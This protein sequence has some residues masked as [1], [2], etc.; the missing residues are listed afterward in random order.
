MC[1]VDRNSGKVTMVKGVILKTIF[2]T[3]VAAV[4]ILRAEARLFNGY[5]IGLNGVVL[6]DDNSP[7]SVNADG[8][9]FKLKS[10]N[11]TRGYFGLQGELEMSRPNDLYGALRVSADF[12]I[13]SHPNQEVV[14]SNLNF[15]MGSGDTLNFITGRRKL[16]Q[17]INGEITFAGGYNYCNRVAFF[18]LGGFRLTNK[19]H[20]LRFTETVTDIQGVTTE[21]TYSQRVDQQG[22]PVVG[23]GFMSRVDRRITAGLEYRFAWRDEKKF[24]ISAPHIKGKIT[25]HDH[26]VL[27]RIRYQFCDLYTQ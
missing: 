27:A 4:T 19:V 17:W 9:R 18:L 24:K 11:K 1:P 26:A 25:S 12:V 16:R 10:L 7:V 20:K 14:H 15:I 13:G 8:Y 6:I 23:A 5:S 22:F 3:S 2:V 21:T